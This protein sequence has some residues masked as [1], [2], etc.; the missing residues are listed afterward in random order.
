MSAE[1]ALMA[2]VGLGRLYGLRA[3]YAFVAVG[4]GVFVWPGV[5]DPHVMWS[6][7]QGETQC[8]LMAFSLMCVLGIRYPVAMLP[9]FLWEMTW[10]TLWLTIVAVPQWRSGHMSPEVADA[11]F[12]CGMVVLVYAAVPW[13]YV[14]AQYILAAGDPWRA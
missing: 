2:R 12:A 4:L 14:F 7:P 9:V 8:M 6:L 11:A 5:F 1:E 3:M 13:R 10:K